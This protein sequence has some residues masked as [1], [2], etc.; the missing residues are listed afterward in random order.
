M[1]KGMKKALYA[2]TALATAG[3][4]ASG[5]AHAAEGAERLQ[6][7][8]HGYHQQWMVLNDIGLTDV[9]D[10]DGD[11][12]FDLTPVDQKHNSEICFEGKYTL[13]NNLTVGI[14]VQLEANTSGDQIDESYLI[15]EG[16]SW[17]RLIIGDENNAAY[18]LQV[19][20]PHG[21]IAH[22]QA[23][24]TAAPNQGFVP[25]AQGMDSSDTTIDGTLLRFDDND[26]G[27]FSYFTPRFGG[28][29]IGASF[30]PNFESGG[31][32]NNSISRIDNA[33]GP[34]NNGAKNGY[35]IGANFKEKF[36]EFGL[37][38]SLG[39]LYGD[40]PPSS[41]GGGSSNLQAASGG[42]Q[43]SF[44]GFDVGGSYTWTN[45]DKVTQGEESY[46][47]Y[48]Y[49]VG[50]VYSVGPYKVGL[51]YMRGETEGLR[52]NASEQHADYLVLSST[53]ALGPGVNV[54]G[55]VYWA[56]LEGEDGVAGANQ[57][58][59]HDLIGGAV[60]VTLSF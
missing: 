18:L 59:K 1:V 39:Y 29:Q 58:A 60:G 43:L 22:N 40:I 23:N 41:G 37:Q 32:N 10:G 3:F 50:V 57:I 13:E 27:K 8:V 53:Y 30:I 34:G 45:G 33:P 12:P 14:N 49:D 4:F 11:R 28:F 24:L 25:L 51:V 20:A 47:G 54:I 55:G 19:T 2:T 44:G 36:G 9:E 15:L 6:V 31:D 46:D 16:D 56:D 7:E 17:G 5:V 52:A 48:S 38:A 21:G 26:S 35:A 42:L